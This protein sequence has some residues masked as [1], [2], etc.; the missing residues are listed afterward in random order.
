MNCETKVKEVRLYRSGCTVRRYGTV[1]LEAGTTPAVIEGMTSTA[2][3]DS[4]SLLFPEGVSGSGIRLEVVSSD[5]YAEKASD[6]KAEEVKDCEQKIRILA[7]QADLYRTLTSA[8][9]G[10]VKDR[11]AFI[12]EF[13][14]L[15]QKNAAES[16]ALQKKK[17][18]LCEELNEMKQKELC[19][20]IHVHMTA[21]K[22]GE[23]PFILQYQERAAYW[24]PIYEIRTEGE[25]EPIEFRIRGEAHQTTGEDWENIRLS[26]LTGNPSST[27]SVPVLYPR[28]VTIQA[29]QP[30]RAYGSSRSAGNGKFAKLAMSFEAEEEMEETA[31]ADAEEPMFFSDS[32]S[33]TTQL[34]RVVSD[35]ADITSETMTEYVLND[36]RDFPK[37][38]NGILV[39]LQ[40][41]SLEGQYRLISVPK[42][43]T[44]AYLCASI[45]TADLP[46][47]INGTASVY[48]KGTYVGNVRV[49]PDL[50]DEKFD[51][52]LGQDD[53][54]IVSRTQT[55]RSNAES[56]L[57]GVKTREI[58]Y[59]IKVTSSR[60]EAAEIL[61]KDQIPLSRDKTVTVDLSE[62]SG[63]ELKEDTGE[64]TWTFT[65]APQEPVTKTFAYTVT[66]P[67]DKTLRE[68]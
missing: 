30:V 31:L 25:G 4:F 46:V 22:A 16:R 57:R 9:S 2:D 15:M 28:H 24:H 60:A 14:E 7:E 52:T 55:K 33:N 38:N 19:P 23:Y 68:D 53:R 39:D 47:M 50:T 37:G 61:I 1:R 11:I 26:L 13:P 63:A 64:L 8:E 40:T 67:R 36:T 29:P 3:T 10:D 51:L 48:L 32:I 12:G 56:K 5:P 49:S 20:L 18:V 34:S 43:D 17:K 21:E 59:E 42:M 65:A 54:V 6:A 58:A 35:T 41:F 45:K 44:H 27:S 66:W 62:K